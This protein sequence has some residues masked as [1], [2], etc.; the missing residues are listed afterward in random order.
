MSHFYFYHIIAQFYL[1]VDLLSRLPEKAGTRKGSVLATQTP[2][3]ETLTTHKRTPNACN[4]G[5]GNNF[6][7]RMSDA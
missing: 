1:R 7:L 6:V 4:L 2:R 3:H 5:G